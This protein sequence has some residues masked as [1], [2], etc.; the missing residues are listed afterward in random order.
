MSS[1]NAKKS[2]KELAGSTRYLAERFIAEDMV[3]NLKFTYFIA[4]FILLLISACCYDLSADAF[5]A[6]DLVRGKQIPVILG[7][8]E[9]IPE[10][11]NRTGVIAQENFKGA[12][13]GVFVDD[14][15]EPVKAPAPDQVT[16]DN[17]NKDGKWYA[18]ITELNKN[19]KNLHRMLFL[20][21]VPIMAFLIGVPLI[22]LFHIIEKVKMYKSEVA[23]YRTMKEK[24]DELNLNRGNANQ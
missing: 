8:A 17:I 7:V 4:G 14:L 21:L 20:Y 1:V 5:E 23:Y 18:V 12:V 11:K 9:N 16:P 13:P 22:T 6:A 15:S 19:L 24:T 2:I 3:K 10:V